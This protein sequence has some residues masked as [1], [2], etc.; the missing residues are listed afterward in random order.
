MD[1]AQWEDCWI[2]LLGLLKEKAVEFGDFTLAS[3]KKSDLY[4]DCRQATLHPQG[5]YLVGKLFYEMIKGSTPRVE[6]V[7]G[8]TLGAD[9]IVTAVSLISYQEGDPIAAFIIRKEPKGHGKGLWIEG[10]ANL[11]KGAVVAIVEDVITT[12]SSCLGAIR[13]AQDFGFKV[14]KVLAIVDRE[15]G[16]RENL[17]REGYRLEPLFRRSDFL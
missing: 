6:G 4:I 8:P 17:A 1:K 9:P 2:K 14:V 13:R 5:G 11:P 7:G 16:G 10:G 12:G 3:G 15:E